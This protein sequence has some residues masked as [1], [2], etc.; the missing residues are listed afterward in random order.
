MARC[1]K[2]HEELNS[3]KLLVLH[4][5]LIHKLTDNC[6]FR[7][8]EKNCS[9]SYL[10]LNSF[11]KH[12]KIHDHQ[13]DSESDLSHTKKVHHPNFLSSDQTVGT[14]R[15]HDKPAL[16]QSSV[17]DLPKTKDFND[18]IKSQVTV[19]ITKLYGKMTLPRNL[20]QDII[21]DFENCFVLLLEEI[22]NKIG[23]YGFSTAKEK[24]A[25]LEMC[26]S[27][28]NIFSEVSSEYLR[29]KFLE[30][31][32]KFLQPE[33]VTI[34]HHTNITLSNALKTKDVQFQFIPLR[35]TLT[36]FF[37]MDN[38]LDLCLKHEQK[39]R[40]EQ[41]YI[42]NVIQGSL[43]KSKKFNTNDSNDLVFPLLIYFD[44]FEVG[45]P[46][47]SHSGINK[48]GAVYASMPLIPHEYHSKLSSIFLCMLFHSMD[49]KAFGN[50]VLFS[51]LVDELN[52]LSTEGIT[53]Q[54]GSKKLKLKFQLL[55]LQG[56][57]LGLHMLIG[58][59]QSFNSNFFC[60]FCRT[61]RDI[62]LKLTDI[63][64]VEQRTKENYEAD[65]SLNNVSLTGIKESCIFNNVKNF[66]IMDNSYCD[67]M[68][69][70][71]E[72]V[73][74]YVFGLILHE[75][76][77]TKKYISFDTFNLKFKYFNYGVESKNRPPLISLDNIRNKQIRLSA[78]EMLC[79]CRYFG[80]ILGP[81]IPKNNIYWKLYQLLHEIVSISTS[82][83]FDEEI[84]NYLEKKIIEHHKLFLRLNFNPRFTPKFH[85]LLHLPSIILLT[86]P[87]VHLWT[88]RYESKHK[89]LKSNAYVV[90]SRTNICKTLAIKCQLKACEL[91]ISNK[92]FE[93]QISKGKSEIFPEVT[94]SNIEEKTKILLIENN[95]LNNIFR[96]SSVTHYGVKYQ[97]GNIILVTVEDNYSPVFGIIEEIFLNDAQNIA[98]I[99]KKMKTIKFDNHLM[100]YKVLALSD[101][102]LI[103]SNCLPYRYT[104]LYTILNNNEKYV[105]LR[106]SAILKNNKIYRC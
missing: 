29:F 61:H 79:L 1:F 78:S 20:V 91:Y 60:R 23:L 106:Y 64:K 101:I 86:G 84:V 105:T 97:K 54:I 24:A 73:C 70:L 94:A 81:V 9:R 27:L 8:S 103:S 95:F 16:D 98:F 26:A 32:K 68:H 45:N 88:M 5:R 65:L 44:E 74:K 104:L 53:L 80:I 58:F 18:L 83:N 99:F 62:C 34:G 51:R 50:A 102:D 59:S 36:C 4:F 3:L 56:D 93:T 15:D 90:S 87:P 89:E 14:I 37:Q 76:I 82:F 31:S 12:F 75:L 41:N 49:I 96:V 46:L 25:V 52:Y 38:V 6:I 17:D 7:C 33:E 72:G 30:K 63:N 21:N 55:L 67:I 11:K 71:L 48:L 66:H 19:L 2:C 39:L 57:N 85:F 40:L 35:H 28:Q 43:W 92:G 69:D 100:S 22:K 47:G 77:I 10:S 42:S 13:S